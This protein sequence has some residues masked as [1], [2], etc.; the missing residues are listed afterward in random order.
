MSK[1]YRIE[2]SAIQDNNPKKGFNRQKFKTVLF[3]IADI[4]VFGISITALGMKYQEWKSCVYHF[5]LWIETVS[6]LGGLSLAINFVSYYLLL[7]IQNF[8][9]DQNSELSVLQQEYDFKRSTEKAQKSLLYVSLV[10]DLG[11]LI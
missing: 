2:S 8:E 4:A 3:F 10:L 9:V 5:D 1:M 6:A 7:K 11:M